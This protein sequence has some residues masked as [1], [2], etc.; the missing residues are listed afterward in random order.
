MHGIGGGIYDAVTDAIASRMWG[1]EPLAMQVVSAALYL[2]VAEHAAASLPA[3]IQVRPE[4]H[5]RDLQR[6]RSSPESFLDAAVP[7]EAELQT[8]HEQLLSSRPAKGQ[9]KAWH[10]EMKKLREVIRTAIQPRIEQMQW[11]T[12]GL[13]EQERQN[14]IARSRESSFVL[15]PEE[16]IMRRLDELLPVGSAER[17]SPPVISQETP[18]ST[19][20]ADTKVRMDVLRG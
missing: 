7:A 19:T 3:V 13:A 12:R 17:L 10:W 18:S 6:L 1:L 2:P 8:L 15:F 11:V 16:D 9:R 5:R 20:F 4:V 14:R